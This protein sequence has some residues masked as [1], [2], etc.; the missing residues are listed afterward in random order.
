MVQ[1]L[2]ALFF[3]A[4]DDDEILLLLPRIRFLW[5]VMSR[6]CG[7]VHRRVVSKS[8]YGFTELLLG[9]YYH[10]VVVHV[11]IYTYITAALT[12]IALLPRL[13]F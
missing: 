7:I 12:M 8:V 3:A 2:K 10:I 13:T 4:A 6:W 5:S 11:H 1:R 9:A